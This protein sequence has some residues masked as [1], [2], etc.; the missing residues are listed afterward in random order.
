MVFDGIKVADFAWM[1]VGAIVTR[2]LAD[3]GA[4]VIKIESRTHPDGLRFSR[5]FRDDKQG[6]N[7]SG[8]YANFNS[9]KYGVTLNLNHPKGIEIAKRIINWADILSEAFTPDTMKRWGLDYESVKLFKPDIIYYSTSQ[10]GQTG[11]EAAMPGHGV[12]MG[13]YSG[14]YHIT[15]WPDRA[16]SYVYGAYPDFIAPRFILTALIGALIY[17]NRTGEGQYIENSQL[18]SAIQ[19][20]SPAILQYSISGVVS[21]RK[22][23]RHNWASPH[24]AFRCSG[25]EQWLALGIFG[26]K[27]WSQFK[28]LLHDCEWLKDERFETVLGR[29]ENED[30]LE[31]LVEAWT[32]SYSA[33]QLEQ[34]LQKAG[35][36][37]GVVQNNKDLFDDIQ[38]KD[39]NHFIMMKHP[40]MGLSAY[41]AHGFRLC[42]TPAKFNKPAPCLGEH[43]KF[44][45]TNI[46]GMSDEEFTNFSREG[47][48]D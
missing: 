34:T 16:P 27:D 8:L 25:N 44:V 38:L 9:N 24:G 36:S 4:T 42:R 10:L 14:F 12:A 23:N 19:F 46:L 33:F 28:E 6:L 43:N 35:L 40:E 21:A 47:V 22:G 1:G 30:E 41:D 18:E 7:R 48:F 5:P 39:R 2:Y 29:K 20:L 13:A 31:K 45:Y 26:N 32:I 11:P 15:G 17:R 37:A 3:F